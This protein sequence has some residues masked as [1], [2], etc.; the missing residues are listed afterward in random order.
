MASDTTPSSTASSVERVAGF[1]H[2]R[3]AVVG[4]RTFPDEQLV[5]NVLLAIL[6]PWHVVVTGGAK[7]V[8]TWAQDIATKLEVQTCVHRPDWS[9]G[10]GAGLKRNT[11]I[12]RDSDVVIAFWDGQ[13]RGTLDSIQKAKALGKIVCVVTPDGKVRSNYG[14]VAT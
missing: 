4:S 10:K 11:I 6:K 1:P 13:S 5:R 3:L 2:T 8:D 7:G 12:V 9:Q 14:K